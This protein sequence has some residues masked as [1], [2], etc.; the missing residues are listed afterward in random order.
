MPENTNQWMVNS[1][2]T[3]KGPQVELEVD[4]DSDTSTNTILREESFHV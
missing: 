4:D 2:K 3:G 1:F